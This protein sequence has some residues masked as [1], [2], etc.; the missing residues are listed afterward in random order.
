[1]NVN[2]FMSDALTKD[3]EE[4]VHVAV[5][6][7]A[8]LGLPQAHGV[9]PTLPETPVVVRITGASIKKDQRSMSTKDG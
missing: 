1:M 7:A 3:A 2:Y 6:K 5:A 8:A 9:A 4:S